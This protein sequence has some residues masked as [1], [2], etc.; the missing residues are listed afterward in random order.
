MLCYKLV[1][2]GICI[3]T[4]GILSNCCK[5][6][7]TATRGSVCGPCRSLSGLPLLP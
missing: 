5:G 4:F 2:L 3:F 1:L 6:H 7:R